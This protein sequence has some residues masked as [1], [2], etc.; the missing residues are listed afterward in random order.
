ME[1]LWKR[2]RACLPG[3]QYEAQ[4]QPA[5]R[6]DNIMRN[7][8]ACTVECAALQGYCIYFALWRPCLTAPSRSRLALADS[9]LV[10][11][12]SRS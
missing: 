6:Y 2:Y 12:L 11:F 3:E 4:V 1:V 7:Q 10:P 5:W 9:G 8:E